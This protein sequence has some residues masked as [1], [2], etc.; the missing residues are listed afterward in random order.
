VERS[1]D[2]ATWTLLATTPAGATSYSATLLA[3]ST[4]YYFRVRATSAVGDSAFSN[5]ASASTQAAGDTG[6]KRTGTA[7]GTTGSWNNNGNDRT[8]AFDGSLGTFFDAPVGDRVWVGLDLG[9]AVALT[10]IKYAPRAGYE[11]RM[12]GGKVQGSSTADFSAGVVDLHTITSQP[13]AGQLTAVTV[14]GS[15]RYVRYLSPTDGWGNIAELEVWGAAPVINRVGAGTASASSAPVGGE[16]AAQAFD[17]AAGTKWLGNTGTAGGVWLRYDFGAGTAF[18]ITQYRVTSANDAPA[19]DPRDWVL[20]ASNDGASWAA[21]D[22][23][24]GQT[25]ADRLT[26]NT[27]ALANSTA[28]RYYRLRVTA[29]AGSTETN[30]G[31]TGLVQLAEL[32]LWG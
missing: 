10:Q 26:T 5:T 9:A 8:K 14:G 24:S 4:R 21:L 32:S 7:I 31:G 2:Q 3:S 18:A 22:T 13:A 15:F 12:V 29:N 27:Y 16:G 11:G 23:R 1:T 20:E 28:Y 19:R 25:F 30:L 17:G 6:V